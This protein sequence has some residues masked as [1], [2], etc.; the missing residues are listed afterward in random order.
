MNPVFIKIAPKSLYDW[1]IDRNDV[2]TGINILLSDGT[3]SYTLFKTPG[4]VNNYYKVSRCDYTQFI[5]TVFNSTVS[6]CVINLDDNDRYLIRIP[7]KS[8][9]YKVLK[10]YLTN[11]KFVSYIP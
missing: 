1:H 2:T 9:P 11:Y 7:V 8:V 4:G 10:D 3:N 5:P 6:H